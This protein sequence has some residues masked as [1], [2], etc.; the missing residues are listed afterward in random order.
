M[1]GTAKR[2]APG[3]TNT[4]RLLGLYFW[5]NGKQ[6]TAIRWWSKAIQEGE[7]LGARPDLSRTYLEVGK[8]LLEPQSRYRDLN[9]LTAN[10]YLAKA[11]KLFREMDLQWDQEQLERVRAG[12]PIKL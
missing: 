5:R 12:G 10:D 6:G 11:E 7:R 2:Y 8:R 4:L 3:R 1:L 9:G